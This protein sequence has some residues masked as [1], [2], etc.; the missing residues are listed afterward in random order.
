MPETII[1]GLAPEATASRPLRGIETGIV[2]KNPEQKHIEPIVC[3][4]SASGA[5]PQNG[6]LESAVGNPLLLQSDI[7]PDEIVPEFPV[8]L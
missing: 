5:A 1:H 3:E 2:S 4:E 7:L 8:E 6:G